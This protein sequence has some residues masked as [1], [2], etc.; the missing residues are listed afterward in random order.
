M[1][2]SCDGLSVTC[3]GQRLCFIR[4]EDDRWEGSLAKT[5]EQAHPA[6][7]KDWST[8]YSLTSLWFICR[9]V[10]LSS[11]AN[12]SLMCPRA[13]SGHFPLPRP[14]KLPAELFTRL[15]DSKANVKL[16]SWQRRFKWK[17]A[18]SQSL[19]QSLHRARQLFY[20]RRWSLVHSRTLQ[21][22][23]PWLLW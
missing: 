3:R 10:W 14:L 1:T 5:Q 6:E 19:R 9:R 12:C 18:H 16:C 11:S 13:C 23:R 21:S 4:L 20:T 8:C 2:T 22:Q 7:L 15:S 17:A